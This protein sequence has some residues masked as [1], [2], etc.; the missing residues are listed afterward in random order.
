MATYTLEIPDDIVNA[1][2]PTFVEHVLL[3]KKHETIVLLEKQADYGP[4]NIALCPVG[5]LNGL[6][7]RLY[8]KIARLAN[9][10]KVQRTPNNEALTDTGLD[11]ANYGTIISMVLTAHWPNLPHD[12]L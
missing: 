9:L 1:V 2:G 7:V 8:D 10:T 12:D 3:H 11:I 6:L 5:P 4:N